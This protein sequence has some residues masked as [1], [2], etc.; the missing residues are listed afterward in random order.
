MTFK[1][2]PIIT[3][4]CVLLLSCCWKNCLGKFDQL[5]SA[6]VILAP[7]NKLASSTEKD[8]HSVVF[9][10]EGGS[11]YTIAMKHYQKANETLFDLIVKANPFITNVRKIAD[12][13]KIIIPAITPES[14]IVKINDGEY[15][16][17]MGTFEAFESAVAYSQKVTE[18]EKLLFIESKEFSPKDTWYS[19]TMGDFQNREEA[20]KTV[21]RLKEASLIYI[22][23][24]LK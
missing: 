2:H 3:A 16:V 9:K 23:T 7:T 18:P 22:P 17:H 15:R 6:D 12:E 14:Y 8:D 13:Q 5:A 1:K 11:L 19:L 24:Q 20:F 4:A 21:I 10:E